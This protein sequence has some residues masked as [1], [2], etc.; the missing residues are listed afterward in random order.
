[1]NGKADP[2]IEVN[3]RLANA[4]YTWTKLRTCWTQGELVFKD[5][6]LI[7]DAFIGSKLTYGLHVLPLRKDPM[8]TCDAFFFKVL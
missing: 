4:R 2:A 7:Y 6:L 1:M 5:K 8:R 3:R